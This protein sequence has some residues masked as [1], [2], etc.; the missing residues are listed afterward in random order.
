LKH[1]YQVKRDGFLRVLPPVEGNAFA[2]AQAKA[3]PAIATPLPKSVERAFFWQKQD[4]SSARMHGSGKRR[5]ELPI[6]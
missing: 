6:E 1:V 4:R 5:V 2:H 3:L